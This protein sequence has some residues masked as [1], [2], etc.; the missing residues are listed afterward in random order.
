MQPTVIL[1]SRN[2]R[3]GTA[4]QKPPWFSE[5]TAETPTGDQE[6]CGKWFRHGQIEIVPRVSHRTSTYQ[7]PRVSVMS[8]FSNG[9]SQLKERERATR[10]NEC[11]SEMDQRLYPRL[12]LTDCPRLAAVGVGSVPTALLASVYPADATGVANTTFAARH[13]RGA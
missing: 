1:R 9:R 13:S 2:F 10:W 7:I 5:Q 6:R 4:T 8:S 11:P 3:H 12:G